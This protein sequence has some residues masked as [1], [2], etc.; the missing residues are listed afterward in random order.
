MSFPKLDVGDFVLVR[1]WDGG[2]SV[3]VC[4]Y[5]GQTGSLMFMIYHPDVLLACQ[6]E[7]FIKDTDSMPYSVQIVRKDSQEW[8][9]VIKNIEG[10]KNES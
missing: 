9:E 3:E 6:A 10:L 1:Q 8:N 7:R 2:Q 5:R 4:Q